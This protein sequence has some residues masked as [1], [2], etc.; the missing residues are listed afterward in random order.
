MNRHVSIALGIASVLSALSL[1]VPARTV[2]T[3]GT[4]SFDEPSWLVPS[5]LFIVGI[6]LVAF[7]WRAKSDREEMMLSA[8]ILPYVGAALGALGIHDALRSFVRGGASGLGTFLRLIVSGGGPIDVSGAT[9]TARWSVWLL[10]P[11]LF[12]AG[13]LAIA[14]TAKPL[15]ARGDTKS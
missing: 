14:A 3:D 11:M 1:L 2:G 7:G 12:I 13:L 6:G 15:A 4:N 5:L 9:M 8:R 10:D